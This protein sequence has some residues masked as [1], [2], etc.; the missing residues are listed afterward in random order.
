MNHKRQLRKRGRRPIGANLGQR[1]GTVSGEPQQEWFN[2]IQ[3]L[4]RAFEWYL[5]KK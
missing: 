5:I 3:K 2:R 1:L 4:N